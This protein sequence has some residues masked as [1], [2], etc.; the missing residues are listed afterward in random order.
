[1]NPL[2]LLIILVAAVLGVRLFIDWQRR[3]GA[4]AKRKVLTWVVIAV[5][6][7]LTVTGKLSL[8][9]PVLVTLAAALLRLAPLLLQLLPVLQRT[10]RQHQTQQ[11][12]SAGNPQQSTADSKYVHLTL[13]HATGD[14]SG[15]VTHGR[16]SGRDL[17]GL[18]LPELL[19]CYR[20]CSRDDAESAA[21]LE[22]Y[23][24]RVYGEQWRAGARDG[25]S[26]GGSSGREISREDAY[27]VLGLNP[28]A[29]RDAIIQAHRRLM[30]KLHPDRGGSDY[31]A[32]EI[33]RAKEILLGNS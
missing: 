24:D 9:V 19:D 26:A 28:G 13:N 16:F 3:Q 29:S 17:H 20:E 27:R 18:S 25:G 12:R 22:A 32:A 8:I 5:L 7:F 2:L 14:I 31:L 33:N 6:V 10:W 30:Q 11:A 4:A 15:R 1:M 23:L 21:L